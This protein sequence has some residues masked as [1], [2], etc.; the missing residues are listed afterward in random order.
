MTVEKVG[1]IMGGRGGASGFPA[2]GPAGPVVIAGPQ[3]AEDTK[4]LDELAEYMKNVGQYGIHVDKQSLSGQTF[5][6]VRE[7]AGAIER[8]MLAFP[9]AAPLFHDLRGGDLKHG[10]LAQ[11]S[12]SGA[13][14]LANHYYSKTEDGLARTYDGTTAKGFHPAGTLKA[15]IASHEAGHLL[16]RALIDKYIL[17]KGNDYYTRLEAAKAWNKSTIAGK[18]VS[19]A[20]KVVKKTP[21]GKGMKN[22]DL[23]RNVSGYAT[24]NRAETLAECVADYAANGTSAKPLSVAVWNIL[25]REL[26]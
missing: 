17:S 15:D 23:I 10:V 12:Y 18:V 26:G 11:A 25:K 4:D 14:E 16:D 3:R 19:E 9:Q 24:K 13:I 8:I 6:N 5:E 7:A 1:A 20:C 2:N 21:E 22:A